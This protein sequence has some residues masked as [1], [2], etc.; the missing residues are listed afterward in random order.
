MRRFVFLGV[1]VIM[2]AVQVAFTSAQEIAPMKQFGQAMDYYIDRNYRDARDMLTP[3]CDLVP[4]TTYQQLRTHNWCGWVRCRA[5]Y[6]RG[7]C[8][9]KLGNYNEA[10]EDFRNVVCPNYR[11]KADFMYR[12][13]AFSNGE[14]D[15]LREW[16][17]NLGSR[18]N[19]RLW[20][21]ANFALGTWAW[22]QCE[23]EDAES[24]FNN[25]LSAPIDQLPQDKLSYV[26]FLKGMAS[27]W[28][29][30][31][32]AAI[33]R[34]A[35]VPADNFVHYYRTLAYIGLNRVGEA[36]AQ[37]IGISDS[38]PL[39]QGERLLTVKLKLLQGDFSSA[40][41]ALNNFQGQYGFQHYY[42]GWSNLMQCQFQQAQNGF[43]NF[44]GLAVQNIECWLRKM[45]CD[46]GLRCLEV[47]F[48]LSDECT[49]DDN[50]I[51]SMLNPQSCKGILA[52]PH[53]REILESMKNCVAWQCLTAA[54]ATG[55]ITKQNAGR[56]CISPDDSLLYAV[57]QTI[58]NQPDPQRAAGI[59]E[60]LHGN[61]YPQ[62]EIDYALAGVYM[63]L[64][65]FDRARNL[66]QRLVNKGSMEACYWFGYTYDG[67]DPRT[68]NRV[69]ACQY[70][71]KVE[72]TNRESWVKGH[73]RE[74]IRDLIRKGVTCSNAQ[75]L[76]DD[77]TRKI[78]KRETQMFLYDLV[79]SPDG[80]LD[81]LRRKF[82]GEFAHAIQQYHEPFP[83]PDLVDAI[84]G[85]PTTGIRLEIYGLEGKT[86]TVIVNRDTLQVSESQG[87]HQYISE[88][89]VKPGW[90]KVRIE[91]E[92]F[93]DWVHDV[94]VYDQESIPVHLVRRIEFSFPG[95]LS[96]TVKP[97]CFDVEDNTPYLL[98]P[99]WLIRGSEKFTK[100]DDIPP[101]AIEIISGV[102]Y[103]VAEDGVVY[104]AVLNVN[105]KVVSSTEFIKDISQPI[106][107]V[108][109]WMGEQT[110]FVIIDEAEGILKYNYKGEW[111]DTIA[112]TEDR[113]VVPADG[114]SDKLD[115]LYVVDS[116]NHRV[117]KFD[118]NLN[119]IGFCG[120]DSLLGKYEIG[121]KG[122]PDTTDGFLFYPTSV[123]IDEDGLIYVSDLSGRIQLFNTDGSHLATFRLDDKAAFVAKLSVKGCGKGSKLYLLEKNS[124]GGNLETQ[125]RTV[126]AK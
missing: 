92:G 118:R 97:S 75:P 10:S 17:N 93:F 7:W 40:I 31:W 125:L 70:Y 68:L 84:L 56:A 115:N 95:K 38:G 8:N 122:K 73:A 74:R 9:Y 21:M 101:M 52:D 79:V 120:I 105:N 37:L 126:S 55:N 29:G 89:T 23:A 33:E 77:S 50:L 63:T 24:Y 57:G 22:R 117:L 48:I 121:G 47:E 51:N 34:L 116:G 102:P 49:L 4:P 18:E 99:C 45:R 41:T 16:V 42:R 58:G 112:L 87:D 83:W 86:P 35:N 123:A 59:L 119:H 69:S 103:I 90:N 124:K 32:Q 36:E 76:P 72:T 60:N 91:C 111:T 96:T 11:S 110:E 114:V 5:C 80:A 82:S 94:Y 67:A 12:W 43:Q 20:L 14:P 6:W 109:F 27:C 44:K 71:K 28:L 1:S 62:D 104:K 3:L 15:S 39:S 46:A 54:A 65:N 107:V 2:L 61:R 30:N 113:L 81:M 25:V 98:S 100:E 19:L 66:L 88:R 106:D 53:C 85:A 64:R 26:N 13:C 78:H 108:S